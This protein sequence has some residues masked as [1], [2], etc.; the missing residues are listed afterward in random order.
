MSQVRTGRPK[1]EQ[2]KPLIFERIRS[3][4]SR[5]VSMS[6]KTA[7]DLAKYVAWAAAEVGAEEDEALTLTIDQ[8]LAQF[9]QRDRLFQESLED[10]TEGAVASA[11]QGHGSI[12][13]ARAT[14]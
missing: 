8:A 3:K 13:A 7:E 14:P 9:F 2:T 11:Q 12:P 4:V 10:K 6:A 1:K 5:E